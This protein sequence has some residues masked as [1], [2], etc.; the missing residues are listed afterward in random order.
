MIWQKENMSFSTW[1]MADMNLF[2]T[3]NEDFE[4]NA[5][6]EA[7]EEKEKFV[8]YTFV[9]DEDEQDSFCDE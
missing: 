7:F 2:F 3:H 6:Q 4:V 8:E 1:A 5:L 9:D